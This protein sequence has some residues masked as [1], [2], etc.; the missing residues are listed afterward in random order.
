MKTN[1]LKAAAALGL[2]ALLAGTTSAQD[3]NNGT[4]S[5][6]V[7]YETIEIDQQ[8]NY[9]GLRLVGSQVLS[10]TVASVSGDDVTLNA[11]AAE[12][13]EVIVEINS[14]NAAGAV[15][16]G[17][18]VGGVVTVESGLAGDLAAADSVTLREPQSL[19]SVFGDPV[20]GVNDPAE[21]LSGAATIEG[22]DLVL[23]PEGTGFT[24]YWYQIR[25]FGNEPGWRQFDPV[26]GNSVEVED[27]SA[28]SLVYTDGVIVNNRSDDNTLVVSGSVKTS[29]TV[30]ALDG[31][32]NYL[33]TVYPAG[34]TLA[35]A[36]NVPGTDDLAEGSID[37]SG[38]FGGADLVLI[39]SDGGFDTY[40]YFNGGFNP[41]NATWRQQTSATTFEVVDADNISLEDVTSI[42][43]QNRG[44][45]VQ[46]VGVTPPAFY[47]NL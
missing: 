25:V 28:I 43:V 12:D 32:F 3:T 38:T 20:N 29:A 1:T 33:S 4:A 16:M 24:T 7:G 2:S 13:G 21:G 10:S 39:P 11:S 14:G 30:A 35:S 41:A 6:P 15:V 45:A 26:T 37:S 44:E 27:A 17:D 47:S 34:A 46:G 8:F 19:A 5:T 31:Q 18:V 40:W 36:F 9:V 23:V 22:A 42:V